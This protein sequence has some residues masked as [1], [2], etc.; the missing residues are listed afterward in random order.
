VCAHHCGCGDVMCW[1][2]CKPCVRY[3]CCARAYIRRSGVEGKLK[4]AQLNQNTSRTVRHW[5][6]RVCNLEYSALLG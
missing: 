3:M 4:H 2:V 1:R 6:V 5:N